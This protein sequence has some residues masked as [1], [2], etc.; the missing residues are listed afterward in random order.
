MSRFTPGVL[1][2]WT[3][4][5]LLFAIS[6]VT[7]SSTALG[8]S[9]G[10]SEDDEAKVVDR[11]GVL[12][13]D[14]NKKGEKRG[15]LIIAPIPISSPAFGSGLL[16]I[17]GYVFKFNEDDQISP[18]SWLGGAGVFTNNGS[19]GLALGGRLYLQEN[20][21]QATFAGIKG[22]A[23]LDFFGI[24][25]IPGR[26]PIAVPLRMEGTIFFGELMRNVGRNIFIGPR[27]QFRKL[28]AGID[29]PVSPGGFEVPQIDLKSN[30]AALGFHLQRD[31]RNS[32]FYPTKGNLFDF[33]A[34]FF[35]QVWGSR[36]EYQTYKIGY[37]G[38]RAL[39][40][41]QVFAYR[42]M[43]CS[44]NGSVPFYDLCLYG[45][46]SDLRGYT[47]GEFQNR[48]MFAT[49][50]E[51]RIELPKRLGLVA[52]GGVGGTARQWNEFRSDQFL[53][54]AGAGLRFKLDKKNHINYR[55]DLAFGREGRTISIGLGEAF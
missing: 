38:F 8:Q 28:T 26:S 23:N 31:R 22:R 53:P 12:P 43:A 39:T 4:A 17:S 21:Y 13:D 30:S 35:D 10:V 47:T 16:I 51:Y 48:R 7:P 2:K 46:N 49:Q 37:N 50:A 32:T 33:T 20:K 24:G 54:A 5:V 25:R 44:A 15:S 27:Y 9:E 18:P 34:D 41:K 40:N 3:L 14:K 36:R 45:F 52:F 19:R 1:L 29:G 55:I 42:A 6:I 11:Q